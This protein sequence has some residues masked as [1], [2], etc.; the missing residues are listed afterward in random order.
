MRGELLFESQQQTL[1]YATFVQQ[2]NRVARAAWAAG[3]AVHRWAV[4]Y[5]MEQASRRDS[6]GPKYET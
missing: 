5:L 4:R 2:E 1:F 6:G 3:A